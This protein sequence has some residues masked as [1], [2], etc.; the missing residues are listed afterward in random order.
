MPNSQE[1]IEQHGRTAKETSL[2]VPLLCIEFRESDALTTI[3]G[4]LVTDGSSARLTVNAK[5]TEQ[6]KQRGRMVMLKHLLCN[7][8]VGVY[9]WCNADE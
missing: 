2:A 8:G 4:F 5:L 6:E 7:P 1:N 9:L 3:D